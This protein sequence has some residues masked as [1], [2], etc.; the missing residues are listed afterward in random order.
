MFYFSKNTSFFPAVKDRTYQWALQQHVATAKH[1][2]GAVRVL[3]HPRIISPPIQPPCWRHLAQGT[4]ETHH[5]H[6]MLPGNGQW[7]KKTSTP[8]AGP[9]GGGVSGTGIFGSGWP[10][11]T[12]LCTQPSPQPL[13]WLITSLT[14]IFSDSWLL[15]FHLPAKGLCASSMGKLFE[16]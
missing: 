12:F 9:L 6:R 16:W 3:Q 1:P 13:P 4:T 5:H 8:W 15:L 10:L 14:F 11:S 2:V 7:K